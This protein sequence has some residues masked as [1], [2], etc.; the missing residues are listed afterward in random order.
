MFLL[1]GYSL[2]SKYWIPYVSDFQEDFEVY[3]VDLQGHGNSDIFDED[4]GSNS[5]EIVAHKIICDDLDVAVFMIKDYSGRPYYYSHSSHQHFKPLTPPIELIDK[6]LYYFD[7]NNKIKLVG[8]AYFSEL[9]NSQWMINALRTNTSYCAVNCTNIQLLE[10][11][12][13]D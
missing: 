11:K 2:S 13:N 10:V 5:V 3:L 8:E 1:H 4:C 12:S 9:G 6:G 7:V